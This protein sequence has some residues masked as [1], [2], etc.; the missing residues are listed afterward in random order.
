I[1]RGMARTK[2]AE[3]ARKRM[4]SDEE[5]RDLWQALDTADV[6]ACYPSYV[7]TLLLTAQRRDEV[8]R[9][10]WSE[11]EGSIWIIPAERYKTG[12][13]NVVPFTDTVS[14]LLG[15]RRVGFVF[16]TTSG[17]LPFSGFSKAKHA[18]D[19]T[20]AVLRRAEKRKPIEHWTLH[21]LRRT[22]RSLMSRAGVS[23]DI[24]ERVLGHKIAGV[25]GVYDR[26]E[27]VAEKREALE[28]LAA[29]VQR[30]LRPPAGNVAAFPRA[31]K[32]V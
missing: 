5:L 7:R 17:K 18:L 16:S 24:A 11:I 8:A 19:K 14:Q 20:I 4:L 25:R 1:V 9:M 2:P 22:A 3:R 31:V 12:I 32:S 13:E 30:I 23:A 15:K 6:P 10:N 29:L 27:Y 21:D 26:H 28:G